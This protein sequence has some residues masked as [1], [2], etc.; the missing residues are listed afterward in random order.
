MVNQTVLRIHVLENEL[1]KTGAQGYKI[2]A[3]KRL[4]NSLNNIKYYLYY[5]ITSGGAIFK[6]APDN[7]KGTLLQLRK[8]N[9]I[10]KVR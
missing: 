1:G 10:S 9:H 6:K 4:S 7:G 3:A 5:Y 8:T 2:Y